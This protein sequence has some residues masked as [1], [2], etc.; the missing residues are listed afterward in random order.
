MDAT[1]STYIKFNGSPIQEVTYDGKPHGL[2]AGVYATIGNS[3]VAEA[4]MFYVGV[5]ADDTYYA[6]SELQQKKDIIMSL[7]LIQEAMSIT[8]LLLM[9]LL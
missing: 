6:S 4:D 1:K 2:S 5:L 8:R 3:K 7:P 9:E